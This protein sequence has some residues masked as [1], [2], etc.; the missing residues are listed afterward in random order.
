MNL[1]PGQ[2]IIAPFLPAPAEVKTFEP[3]PGYSLPEVV[4]DDAHHTCKLPRIAED[5]LAHIYILGHNPTA[6][7]RSTRHGDDGAFGDIRY[8]QV[9]ARAQSGAIRLPANEWKKARH[10]DDEFGFTL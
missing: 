4:L 10:F 3:R 7:M 5:Q 6:L 9:K 1:Q 2:R 8:I